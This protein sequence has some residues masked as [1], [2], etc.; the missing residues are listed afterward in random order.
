MGQQ[1][2]Q[3]VS[4]GQ[5]MGD[6]F[7]AHIYN[8][9]IDVINAYKRGQLTNRG[10]WGDT[11]R[12]SGIIHV[13]NSAGV[14]VPRG[15]VLGLIDPMVLPATDADEFH[16]RVRF[17]CGKPTATDVPDRFVITREPIAIAKAGLACISGVCQ[18]TI[19]VIDETHQWA[20]C[21]VDEYAR[22]ESRAFG[23]ARILWKEDGIGDK[24]AIVRL[25]QMP[26]MGV[27]EITGSS[28]AETDRNV[29]TCL[30]SGSL[31]TLD[32]TSGTCNPWT[33]GDSVWAVALNV[34]DIDDVP[35]IRGGERFVAIYLGLYDNGGD[36][37]ALYAIRNP[38]IG[39]VR[40]NPNDEL[41]WLEDQYLNHNSSS[42]Y[43]EGD[44]LVESQTDDVAGDKLVRRFVDVAGYNS[45]EQVL[46]HPAGS[47]IPTW[48]DLVSVTVV[49]DTQLHNS[50]LQKRTSTIK[51]ISSVDKGWSEAFP[52][53]ECS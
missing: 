53:T 18:V 2:Y 11:V 20:G 15:S 50:A 16:D 5:S 45:G 44:L 13:V 35:S 34:C 6:G 42:T 23:G 49:T 40:V 17:H 8:A 7:P 47:D 10:V 29:T 24:R 43:V 38:D 9:M 52:A 19:N 1:G 51:T 4:V 31:M 28:C 21:K 32:T 26:E 36:E 27:V 3:K 33:A 41:D 22:L 14:T 30:W 37:R 25:A 12:T 39:K 46:T 48:V